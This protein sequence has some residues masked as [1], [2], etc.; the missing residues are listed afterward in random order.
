MNEDLERRIVWLGSSFFIISEKKQKQPRN[1][2]E[3]HNFSFFFHN[4]FKFE[5]HNFFVFKVMVSSK[6]IFPI[7]KTINLPFGWNPLQCKCRL[8]QFLIV[9]LWSY[10]IIYVQRKISSCLN[11]NTIA[12]GVELHHEWVPCCDKMGVAL[13]WGSWRQF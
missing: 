7:P 3:I 6:K 8:Y 11:I 12:A 13:R 2:L 9:V 10:V 4:F 5:N 1:K